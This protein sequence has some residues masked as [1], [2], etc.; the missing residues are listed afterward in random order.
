M[1]IIYL[2]KSNKKDENLII[3]FGRYFQKMSS[4]LPKEFREGEYTI[5]FDDVV[6]VGWYMKKSC[7]VNTTLR[8]KNGLLHSYLLPS[9]EIIPKNPNF[10]YIAQYRKNGLFHKERGY[11][12]ISRCIECVDTEYCRHGHKNFRHYY[13]NGKLEW[14]D[15]ISK[16]RL[17]NILR[18]D[19]RIYDDINF[20]IMS[21]LN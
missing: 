15:I 16:E 8:L 14:C 3:K 10:P 11:A 12:C 1:N 13:I 17:K 2:D 7:L 5:V 18:K 20:I 21:Y 9:I 6:Y 4:D 19:N